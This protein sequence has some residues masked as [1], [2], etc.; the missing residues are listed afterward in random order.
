MVPVSLGV[1]A[2]AIA[3]RE[4][5]VALARVGDT[6]QRVGAGR[7]AVAAMIV[8]AQDTALASAQE[9]FTLAVW[10]ERGLKRL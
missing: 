5:G 2:R 9:S 6:R 7:V 1:D 3:Q 10:S 4:L 8:V